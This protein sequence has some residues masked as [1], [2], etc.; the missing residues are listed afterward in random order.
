VFQVGL[1]L[2][3]GAAGA[4]APA[5]GQAVAQAGGRMLVC[6]GGQPSVGPGA[7]PAA[8]THPQRDYLQ[9]SAAAYLEQLGAAAADASVSVDVFAGS[10]VPVT[11]PCVTSSSAVGEVTLLLPLR[12]FLRC[13]MLLRCLERLRSKSRRQ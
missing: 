11:A 6:A 3:R 2:L 4:A 12:C 7:W 8:E 1:A 5:G 13:V 9:A 10:R